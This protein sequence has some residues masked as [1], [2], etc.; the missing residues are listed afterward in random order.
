M[1]DVT[2]KALEAGA[3]ALTVGTG[4]GT[5]GGTILGFLNGNAPALGLLLTLFFGLASL[6]FQ[7]K[8]NKELRDREIKIEELRIK[9]KEMENN[10]G[11]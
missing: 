4:V 9:L 8:G 2:D 1:K 11:C 5:S 3:K 7:R 6:Y 10:D